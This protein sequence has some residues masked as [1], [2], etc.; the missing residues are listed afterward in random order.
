VQKFILLFTVLLASNVNANEIILACPTVA[1]IGGKKGNKVTEYA[2]KISEH[3]SQVTVLHTGKSYP[4]AVTEMTYEWIL[5][6][7]PDGS[8]LKSVVNR[9]T[10]R[11]EMHSG[12]ILVSSGSCN[13]V[14]AKF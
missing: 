2:Y 7:S 4:L 13:K 9:L 6:T 5:H 14:S 12:E 3:A 8:V 1:D 10:G 11:Y